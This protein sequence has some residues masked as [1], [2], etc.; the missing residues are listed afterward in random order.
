MAEEVTAG[1]YD[2]PIG[3]VHAYLIADDG[4]TMIDSGYPG[5][6]ERILTAVTQL[7]KKAA[8]LKNVVLTHYHVDHMGGLAALKGASGATTYAHPADVPYIQ[9]TKEHEGYFIR[10]FV[11]RLV[12]PIWGRRLRRY[13]QILE[14]APVDHGVA[15]GQELPFSGGL[16][17]IHTPGHTPGH[18]SVLMRPKKVLFVGDAAASV[19]GLRAPVGAFF[20]LATADVDQAKQSFRKIAELDF[21]IACFGHGPVLKG[22]AN[23]A[24]RRCVEKAAR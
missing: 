14:V 20:G 7:G 4:L 17:V 18:I 3:I 22:Q 19:F 2:I 13:R 23:V 12:A 8:D 21:D 1:I 9:G 16:K 10:S 11:D 6:T 24:F 15:D 5:E